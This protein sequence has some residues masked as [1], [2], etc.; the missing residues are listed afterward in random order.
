MNPF[1]L[2]KN[3]NSIIKGFEGSKIYKFLHLPI[4]SGDDII[5]KKM[6]RNY[7]VDDCLNITKNFKSRY[8]DI[9]ISTDIIVGFPS[10]TDK[11][12]QNTINVLNKIKPDITNITRFSPRPNTKA[13][14]MVGRIKTETV[15][16][17]SKTLTEKCKKIS[18]DNNKKL[19]GDTYNILITEQGKNKTFIGR[20]ENYKQVIV[21]ENVKIGEFLTV[22]IINAAP[23]HLFGRLI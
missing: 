4:Q 5:L 23:T 20:A 10:E 3:F 13:K 21:S 17:R 15:K 2:L 11:Q 12:F 7:T 14:S 8:P 6:S 19:V 22:K 1:S 16:E 18:M 9:T